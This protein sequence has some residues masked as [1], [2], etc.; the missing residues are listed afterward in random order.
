MSSWIFPGNTD[1]R[2]NRVGSAGNRDRTGTSPNRRK[3]NGFIRSERPILLRQGPKTALAAKRTV[4]EA[5]RK[6]VFL[7]LFG[8]MPVPFRQAA[9]GASLIVAGKPFHIRYGQPHRPSRKNS[10]K[11][12]PHNDQCTRLRVSVTSAATGL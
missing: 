2:D 12:L 10:V 4:S 3:T 5:T 8:G 9:G 7:R 6:P 11:G 1:Q